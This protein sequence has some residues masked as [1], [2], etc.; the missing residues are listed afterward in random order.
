MNLIFFTLAL[1]LQISAKAQTFVGTFVMS[2][3]DVKVLTPFSA[4]KTGSMLI[5]EDKKYFYKTARLGQKVAPEEIVQTGTDGRAKV[6]FGNGDFINVGPGSSLS[7][8]QPGAD[9]DQPASINLFYGKM[10][11][12]I[13]KTGPRN[14]LKV[15]TPAATAGV[16]GTDFYVRHTPKGSKLSVLRGEVIVKELKAEAKPMTV[17]KGYSAKMLNHKRASLGLADKQELIEIQSETAANLNK[18][19][20]A[21]LPSE[22]KKAVNELNAKTVDATLEEIKIDDPALY[23]ELKTKKITDSSE[24]STM[25]VAK[26]VTQ[27]P[28]K[29][30]KKPS[31]EDLE[32]IGEELYDQ[33][34]KASE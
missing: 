25:T 30:M 12:L 4:D 31:K 14:N 21:N 33:Y 5:Y 3:G 32:A 19:E 22:T 2:K 20:I 24:I 17:K 6:A 34:F 8:P 28:G 13:S 11:S 10:R 23:E 15:K 9:K 29:I 26:L 27:A 1:G 16:R 7:M 18:K